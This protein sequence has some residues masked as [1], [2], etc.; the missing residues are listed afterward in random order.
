MIMGLDLHQSAEKN[1]VRIFFLEKIII[2]RDQLNIR[3][4]GAQNDDAQYQK[5]K[6]LNVFKV[7]L[8]YTTCHTFV[9]Q[10]ISN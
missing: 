9:S 5:I 8:L 7:Y 2:L 10:S 6:Y 4:M 1:Y 3:I